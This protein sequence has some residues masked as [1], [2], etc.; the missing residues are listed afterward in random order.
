MF[1]DRWKQII[2][3]KATVNRKKF[4]MEKIVGLGWSKARPEIGPDGTAS[5]NQFKLYKTSTTRTKLFIM[6]VLFCIILTE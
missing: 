6:I 2:K 1:L 4:V 5:L 3:R